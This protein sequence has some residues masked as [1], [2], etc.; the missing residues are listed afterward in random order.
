MTSL[1]RR[2]LGNAG[3]NK[4]KRIWAIR[5]KEIKAKRN[6]RKRPSLVRRTNEK[7]KKKRRTNKCPVL[8]GDLCVL[9]AGCWCSTTSWRSD[10]QPPGGRGRPRILLGHA[11][12]GG[13]DGLFT[14]TPY[15]QR[16][17]SGSG[18]GSN[19][20]GTRMATLPGCRMIHISPRNFAEEMKS[21]EYLGTAERW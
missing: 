12:G 18:V 11:A 14:S 1:S 17:G 21:T 7:R 4:E 13:A 2:H 16:T 20:L 3:S 19:A 15:G 10:W 9:S 6:S 5:G 8:P